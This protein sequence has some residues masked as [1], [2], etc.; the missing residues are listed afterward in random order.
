MVSESL[1]KAWVK[2]VALLLMECAKM[3]TTTAVKTCQIKCINKADRMN[4][5]ER[6]THVGGYTDKQWKI[7]QQEAVN[8]IESGEWKFWVK[9]PNADSVWVIVVTSRYGHKYLKTEAD[10]EQPNNLLSLPECP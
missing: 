10:G 3:A 7:T 6:I 9:P 5:H 8:Y 4:P 2:R 1:P